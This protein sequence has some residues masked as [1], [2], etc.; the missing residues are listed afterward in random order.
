MCQLLL[1]GAPWL[2]PGS[3]LWHRPIT[4]VKAQGVC[5]AGM[6]WK[7]DL[8]Q[9]LGWADS[10]QTGCWLKYPSSSEAANGGWSGPAPLGCIANHSSGLPVTHVL[11]H[12]DRVTM[13]SLTNIRDESVRGK[14]YTRAQNHHDLMLPL[15]HPR[16]GPFHHCP[17][18]AS[19]SDEDADGVSYMDAV[20]VHW[21]DKDSLLTYD[22]AP[23]TPPEA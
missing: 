5:C 1:I 20:A 15:V 18:C 10:S 7:W 11:P 21:L 13:L 8:S 14:R 16:E 12:S 3:Y 4:G 6:L 22:F 9:V 23:A 2:A 17:W 19:T